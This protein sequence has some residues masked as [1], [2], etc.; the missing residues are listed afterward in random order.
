MAQP[1]EVNEYIE[2]QRTKKIEIKYVGNNIILNQ[3]S[4]DELG[5]ES[6]IIPEDHPI[7]KILINNWDQI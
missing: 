1:K 4:N 7:A 2:S 3:L 6:I 5:F